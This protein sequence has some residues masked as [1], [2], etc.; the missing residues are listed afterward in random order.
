MDCQIDAAAQEVAL[1]RPHKDPLVPNL[2]D[3]TV[4]DAIAGRVHHFYGEFQ[5]RMLLAQACDNKR[6]LGERQAA[7]A[8]TEHHPLPS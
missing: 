6:C 5:G 8:A 3:G 4:L 1:Q 2:R 7:S